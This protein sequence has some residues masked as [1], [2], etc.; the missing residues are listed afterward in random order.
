[1]NV[2][3]LLTRP[4][5]WATAI[6]TAVVSLMTAYV[7]FLAVLAWVGH[8]R[9]RDRTV[10]PAAPTH[11]FAV[12]VPAHDEGANLIATL[13]SLARLDHPADRYTVHVVADHCS[14]DT[15]VHAAAA[16]RR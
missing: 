6:V 15:A 10:V 5:R 8:R 16:E 1:M 3:R 11:T 12:V 13:E 14:D 7:S 9:G 4:F 2:L